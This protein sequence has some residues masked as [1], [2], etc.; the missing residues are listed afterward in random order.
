MSLNSLVIVNVL[1]QTPPVT[2]SNFGVPLL[3]ER[4]L[5]GFATN[6]VRY[7]ETADA[8][9]EDE[10]LTTAAAT[11][12]KAIL[13]QSLH[14]QRVGVASIAADVAQQDTVT[15]AG[16]WAEDDVATIT[17]DGT[18]YSHTVLAGSTAV[19]D[20][21][22]ALRA[23]LTSG[24]T[25]WT[26]GGAAGA[27]V[28]TSPAGQ[29]FTVAVSV[30]SS[31]GT[32]VAANDTEAVNVAT[33]L[34][35][36]LAND[37]AWYCAHMVSRTQTDIERLHAWAESNGERIA[38]SQ[39]GDAAVKAGT[40][41]NV[42]KVLKALNYKRSAIAYYGTAAT[43][44]VFAW[45]GFKLE[46]NLDSGQTNWAHLTLSGIAA[47]TFTAAEGANLEADNVGRYDSLYGYSTTS[48][49]KMANGDY[50]DVAITRDW[51]RAR[52]RESVVGVLVN[53]SARNEKVPFNA[54]GIARLGQA[55]EKTL[56]VAGAGS[57]PHI[58]PGRYKINLPDPAALTLA[59]KQSRTCTISWSAELAGALDGTTINGYLE[60]SLSS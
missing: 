27:V 50:I 31:A 14:V 26:I 25:G 38:I 59:Q 55:I 16:T 19:D 48:P 2:S 45:L 54:L 24:L 1:S 40:A 30:T 12:V 39:T 22:T 10:D 29:A 13:A 35:G 3:L 43:A 47:E 37:S 33:E 21:A 5:S 44:M 18:D 20:V 17:V 28:I 34:V 56:I 4:G 49:L 23:L 36:V 7:Y 57:N 42:A 8:V 46:K 41:G 58:N 9:D 52:I 11:H 51:L 32:L 6:E 60:L 53:A 15:V